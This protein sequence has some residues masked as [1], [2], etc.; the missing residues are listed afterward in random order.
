MINGTLLG[1]IGISISIGIFFL[2]F[3]TIKTQ[4]KRNQKFQKKIQKFLEK[5]KNL[6]ESQNNQKILEYDKILDMCLYEKI[7]GMKNLTTGEKMKK[8]GK[9]KKGFQNENKIWSAHK[10]RNTIAHEIGFQVS[11][12]KF[13]EAEKNFIREISALL[14]D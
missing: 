6:P 14:H 10:L 5:I 12:E 3:L 2:V 8:F 13:L 9:S 7:S 1:I 11:P 4:K